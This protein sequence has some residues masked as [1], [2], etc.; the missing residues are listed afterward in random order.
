MEAREG[1]ENNAMEI[2]IVW[3]G[4]TSQRFKLSGV[5]RTKAG[6]QSDASIFRDRGPRR[7]ER[8]PETR[9]I[10]CFLVLTQPR[11]RRFH[12]QR[13]QGRRCPDLL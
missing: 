2:R 11:R 12:T 3:R 6:C 1:T 5:Q 10:L 8:G 7:D 4:T 9:Y 13:I